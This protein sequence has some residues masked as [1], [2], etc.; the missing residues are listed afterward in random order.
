[1]C[2]AKRL[3]TCNAFCLKGLFSRLLFWFLSLKYFSSHSTADYNGEFE[4]VNPL[5]GKVLGCLGIDIEICPSGISW[6]LNATRRR[7]STVLQAGKT[8][9][10]FRIFFGGGGG[11][12]S[13]V[14]WGWSDSYRK[15]GNFVRVGDK[16][17]FKMYKKDG[18]GR[19]GDI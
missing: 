1:M 6:L 11:V 16:R 19:E 5:S 9:C 13:R 12:A 4:F 17:M 18:V 14:P 8:R 10:T 2:L 15:T 3:H 7:V